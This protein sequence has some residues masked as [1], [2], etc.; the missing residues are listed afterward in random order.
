MDQNLRDLIWKRCGGYCEVCGTS[1]FEEQW[2]AHHRQL[3]SQGGADEPSN[4]MAVHHFCHNIG[5][6]SIHFIGRPAY[7]NGWLVSAYDVPR[8]TFLLLPG[9]RE[10]FLTEDGYYINMTEDIRYTAL[11][12]PPH[13]QKRPRYLDAL[14]RGEAVESSES[15][16]GSSDL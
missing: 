12:G 14:R 7:Q 4:L 11:E 9:K 10:V 6:N 13:E 3:R 16:V 2:A 5:T 8:K 15:G 1:M